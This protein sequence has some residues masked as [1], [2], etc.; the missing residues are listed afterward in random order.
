MKK[1][2]LLRA[3]FKTFQVSS[4]K[5]KFVMAV[6]K[7]QKPSSAEPRFFYGYIVVAAALCIMLMIYGTRFAFGVFFKPVL[8]EFG[9][10]RAMTSGAFS[11]SMVMEGLLGIIM[12]GL[13]DR[14]GPRV[15][16]TLCGFLAGLGYLLM[17]QVNSVWQLYLFYGVII[18]TGM[19]GVF[20]PLVSTVAR[21]FIKRRSM[22]TGIVMSGVGMGALIAAP[23][24]NRLISTYDWRISYIILGSIVLVVVILAAQFLRRDPTQMGQA[25]YGES[26]EEQRLKLGT[27][28]F[29]LS[30]AAYTRQFWMVFIMLLCHGFCMFAISVHIVPHATD[31]GIS[32]TAAANILATTGG[33]A[34]IGRVLMGSAADRIGS[35]QALAIGYVLMSAALFWVVPAK[36]CGC[37]ISL[38]L[39]LASRM[40]L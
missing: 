5:K 33:L 9:W 7:V 1:R 20:V 6:K 16:L 18:G 37:S 14:L 36:R 31:L 15:V 39:S 11:L 30:E 23:M 38:L 10:T 12:G 19:S 3:S 40:G 8:T 13:N 28:G 25:P 2:L 26:K 24:A 34:I 27:E 21:W 4:K 22:M 17:G 32:A 35:R 29:S